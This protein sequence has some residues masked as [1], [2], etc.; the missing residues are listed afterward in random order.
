MYSMNV[1]S[2]ISI[3]IP[4]FHIESIPELKE[5]VSHFATK[6]ISL[7]KRQDSYEIR[8]GRLVECNHKA[9]L[10]APSLCI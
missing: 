8:Q 2:F 5:Y 1:Y 7:L 3:N 9:I 6:S 10:P 4:F